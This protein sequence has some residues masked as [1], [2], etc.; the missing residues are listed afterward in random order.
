MILY[1]YVSFDSAIKIIGGAKISFTKA[2]QFN[3][4]FEMHAISNYSHLINDASPVVS[5]LSTEPST[6]RI[7]VNMFNGVLS[8][9][10]NPLNNLMWSHYADEHRGVVIGIDVEEAG[11]CDENSNIIP[12]NYGDVIYTKTFPK[13]LKT[14]SS[15]KRFNC[16]RFTKSFSQDTFD[17]FKYAY[18]FKGVDWSYEEEVRVLKNVGHRFIDE[19]NEDNE[20]NNYYKN[21]NGEWHHIKISEHKELYL[22]SFP[23]IAIKEIYFGAS[24]HDINRIKSI[25]DLISKDVVVQYCGLNSTSYELVA[26]N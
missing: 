15:E 5:S 25:L 14:P 21:S 13:I 20:D 4:P 2:E 22:C 9:T 8:L 1:K 6:L 17:F 12:A 23:K 11:Y 24:V 10:R 18:L 19:D 26:M 7:G 16:Y 3:D